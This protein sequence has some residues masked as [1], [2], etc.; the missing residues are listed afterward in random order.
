M[1]PKIVH[2][3]WFGGKEKP[4]K[5]K[6]CIESWHRYLPDYQ[7]IEWNEEN[8]DINKY[9]YTKDAY[10]AKKYAF[11][12][13]VARVEALLKY[14]GIYFDTDVEVFRSFDTVLEAKCLLGFEEGNYIATSMMGAVPEYP[15]FNVFLEIYKELSFYDE[16]GKII[17]GTNVT[18]LTKLL[19]EKG[20]VRNNCYQELE[21]EIK[22]YPKEYFSPYVYTYGIYQITDK[23]YCVHHFEV[24]WLP[25]NV[26]IKKKIKKTLVRL[27]GLENVKKLL[28]N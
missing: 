26:K 1:I 14:G 24:S 10:E 15:L 4:T 22:I 20:L 6:R 23:S 3:C 18:K 8:F 28:E 16:N 7:I 12:S 5:V 11:V 9:C 25:W 19:D 21:N 13:D 27:V 17:E 2:Y